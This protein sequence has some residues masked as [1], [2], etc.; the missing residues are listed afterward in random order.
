MIISDNG[1]TQ[2]HGT[3]VMLLAEFTSIIKSMRKF[4]T[5]EI[6]EDFADIMIE[7]AGRQAYMTEKE[8]D[9]AIEQMKKEIEEMTK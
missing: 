6:S 5:Q 7:S 2:L 8:L 9:E 4:L 1:R 3:M